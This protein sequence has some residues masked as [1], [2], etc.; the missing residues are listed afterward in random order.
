MV[1]TVRIQLSTSLLYVVS[2]CIGL[3]NK[4]APSDTTVAVFENCGYNGHDLGFFKWPNYF[5][6]SIVPEVIFWEMAEMFQVTWTKLHA[7]YVKHLWSCVNVSV[8]FIMDSCLLHKLGNK[9]R[10]TQLPTNHVETPRLCRECP[11]PNRISKVHAS[12]LLLKRHI[13]V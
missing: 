11:K 9:G 6:Q 2:R 1:V 7:K 5:S 8:K 4:I 12:T 13:C 10:P 3:S